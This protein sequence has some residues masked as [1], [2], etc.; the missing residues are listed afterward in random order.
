MDV[1]NWMIEMWKEGCGLNVVMYVGVSKNWLLGFIVRGVLID[2][3]NK[4]LDCELFRVINFF[5]W[6]DVLFVIRK[7]LKKF[8]LCIFLLSLIWL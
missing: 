8:Y 6:E 5:K 4:S 2:G 1:F 7:N 3:K